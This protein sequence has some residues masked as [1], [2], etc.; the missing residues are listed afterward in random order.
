VEDCREHAVIGC[1][2]SEVASIRGNGAAGGS[3]AWVNDDKEDGADREKSEARSKFKRAGDDVMWWDVV[4]DV[5]KRGVRTY[6]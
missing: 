3:N 2:K 6:A 4:A 1:H 5:D